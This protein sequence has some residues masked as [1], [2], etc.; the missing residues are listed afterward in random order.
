ME[1]SLA[2]V[3]P[4]GVAVEEGHRNGLV[5]SVDSLYLPVHESLTTVSNLHSGGVLVKEFTYD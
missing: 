5:G 1:E 3:A 2:P 4:A